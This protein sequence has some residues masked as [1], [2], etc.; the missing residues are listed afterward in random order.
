MATTQNARSLLNYLDMHAYAGIT[1]NNGGFR[2]T[3][4]VLSLCHMGDAQEALNVGC[5][6]G[7]GSA[8]VAKTYDCLVVGV[9][10][11]EKMIA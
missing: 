9:D 10:L 7:V 3:D 8:Y 1:K 11:S 6:I 2:A 5:G 4:E